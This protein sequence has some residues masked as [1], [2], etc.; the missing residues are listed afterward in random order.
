MA[1]ITFRTTNEE[2]EMIKELAKHHGMTISDYIKETIMRKIEDELDYK[3]ADERFSVFE[4]TGEKAIPFNDVLKEF[5][6][7]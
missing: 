7:I 6:I 3:I 2:K 4:T 5:G 1:T